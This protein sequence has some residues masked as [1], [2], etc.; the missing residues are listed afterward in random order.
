[1]V[2]SNTFAQTV[3]IDYKTQRFLGN[4]SELDRSKYFNVHANRLSD[5][6]LVRFLEDF[7]VTPGRQF[8]APFSYAK[9]KAD[10]K[11]GVYPEARQTK[12]GTRRVSRFVATDH[13]SNVI[14]WSIDKEKAADWAAEYWKNFVNDNG[15]PEFYEPMNEPVIHAGDSVYAQEQPDSVLMRERM[16]EWF[17]AIGKK[18]DE[19]PELAEMKV[20]GYS[21]AWPS[22]ERYDF[23]HWNGRMKRFMDIA[24]EHVDAISVH[25]YDGINA[26]QGT[27]NFRSGSNSEAILDLIEAYSAIKFGSIK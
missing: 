6:D 16:F 10:N 14:R 24:G 3:T 17:A 22:M 8:W 18:I 1:M 27:S 4:V 2:A 19:T 9:S 26:G 11:V 25:L 13:P 15:R 23:G 12:A 7:N 21:S 20:V 5:P